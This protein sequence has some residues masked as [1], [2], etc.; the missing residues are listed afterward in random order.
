MLNKETKNRHGCLTTLLILLI[1]TSVLT[2]SGL[3]IFSDKIKEITPNYSSGLLY[4]QVFSTII[5][6]TSIYLIFK[7]KKIGFYGVALAYLINLYVTNKM[8]I[9]DINTILGI[10]IRFGLLYGTLQIKSKGISGW[11]NLA[12]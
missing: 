8:G 10:V 7:W 2:T 4:L 5:E 11:N 1:I 3:I 9:M 6:L 12:E